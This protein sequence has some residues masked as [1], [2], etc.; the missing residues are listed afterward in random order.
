MLYISQNVWDTVSYMVNRGFGL[1]Q[2]SA[3][4][5]TPRGVSAYYSPRFRRCEKSQSMRPSF[6][7][8]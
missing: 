3:A 4:V 5:G 2:D 6:S 1:T 7:A 8:M